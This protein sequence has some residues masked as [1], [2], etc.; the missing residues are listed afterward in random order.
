ML[1]LGLVSTFYHL[2]FVWSQKIFLVMHIEFVSLSFISCLP[3]LKQTYNAQRIYSWICVCVQE[4]E[5][6][7]LCLDFSSNVHRYF[8]FAHAIAKD[9]IVSAVVPL[10]YTLQKRKIRE[11]LSEREKCSRK[12]W[13]FLFIIWYDSCT[14]FAQFLYA[15]C[16][17]KEKKIEWDSN[18]TKERIT[19]AMFK[20]CFT[21]QP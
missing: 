18:K 13:C 12:W 16:V 10:V 1:Q 9:K 7:R 8:S 17:C 4:T 11:K 15:M 20:I 14:V 3:L 5:R 19:L 2:H 6:E 21:W